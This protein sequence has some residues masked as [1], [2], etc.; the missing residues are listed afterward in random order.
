MEEEPFIIVKNVEFT[1]SNIYA[2]I[3]KDGDIAGCMS[4]NWITVY[5]VPPSGLGT[6]DTT[7]FEALID[8]H[9]LTIMPDFTSVTIK[10]K[11][12]EVVESFTGEIRLFL[13]DA[14]TSSPSKYHKEIGRFKVV[15]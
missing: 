5:L 6:E 2:K 15:E 14:T 7:S 9:E 8:P 11:T 13:T 1:K 3:K 12:E 10:L 4:A